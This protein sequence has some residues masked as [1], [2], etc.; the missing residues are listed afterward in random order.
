MVGG[1]DGRFGSPCAGA[2]A[3]CRLNRYRVTWKQVVFVSAYV[4]ATSPEQAIA[5][6]KEGDGTDPTDEHVESEGEFEAE[7][8]G[9]VPPG[10][11][12]ACREVES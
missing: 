2:E 4:D 1:L 7:D 10:E 8:T 12:P 9:P 11:A 3:G 5:M 6:A